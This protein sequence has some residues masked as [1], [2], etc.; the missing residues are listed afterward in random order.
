MGPIR[1][2]IS[3]DIPSYGNVSAAQVLAFCERLVALL[4]EKGVVDSSGVSAFQR[5][6]LKKASL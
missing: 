3:L 2:G 5:G 4:F 1:G 6:V